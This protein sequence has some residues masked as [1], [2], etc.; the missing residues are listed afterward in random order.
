MTTRH[1]L[2]A[3]GLA[4]TGLLAALAV[5]CRAADG[6]TLRGPGVAPPPPPRVV[7]PDGERWHTTVDVT[8]DDL[9]VGP[10]V[11]QVATES[12][13]PLRAEKE[14]EDA[15]LRLTLRL[16]AVALEA[17]LAGIAAALGPEYLW[18]PRGET[19]VL[20]RSRPGRWQGALPSQDAAEL[21]RSLSLQIA[22]GR[23][24]LAG[25]PAPSPAHTATLD[26]AGRARELAQA[27]SQL[28][29]TERGARGLAVGDLPP[30][31][32]ADL[33][34]LFVPALKGSGTAQALDSTAFIMAN[35]LVAGQVP[36]GVQL[37]K[38]P[39]GL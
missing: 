10:L 33:F 13:L 22:A 32:Q 24:L 3:T 31:L 30:A 28:V 15:G 39:E 7:L 27:V 11:K 16:R 1:H 12:G 25:S 14:L 6:G 37:Y 8:A 23:G 4:A 2:I 17:A 21:A 38:S 36:A 9:D 35:P 5:P 19:L 29:P 20:Q 18:R 26:S 34:A